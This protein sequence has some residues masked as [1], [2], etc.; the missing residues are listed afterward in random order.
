MSSDVS[1]D[2]EDEPVRLKWFERPSDFNNLDD[3]AGI[4]KAIASSVE[5]GKWTC[6]EFYASWCGSCKSVFPALCKL[7]KD[8]EL[9]GKFQWFKVRDLSV[10]VDFGWAGNFVVA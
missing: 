2:E 10:C 9:S 3:Q 5:N 7:P 6:I 1:A 4:D 8:P